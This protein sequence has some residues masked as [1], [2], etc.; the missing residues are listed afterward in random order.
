MGRK[1]EAPPR[2]PEKDFP[3]VME[4]DLEVVMEF[5]L[6][7]EMEFDLE[8]EIDPLFEH[9]IP[10][11]I[12]MWFLIGEEMKWLEMVVLEIWNEMKRKGS[13]WLE[14]GFLVRI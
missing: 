8:E 7:G 14:M 1:N 5:D 9:Q 11:Q 13:T 10:Y 2:N 12:L 4:F 3:G 6:E